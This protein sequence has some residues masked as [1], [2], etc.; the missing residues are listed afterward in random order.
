MSGH[1]FRLT[2]EVHVEKVERGELRERRDVVRDRASELV[3]AEDELLERRRE[4]REQP[5]RLG[6]RRPCT[7]SASQNLCC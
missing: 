3:A 1:T 5:Q 2:L 7:R 4:R 6:Q